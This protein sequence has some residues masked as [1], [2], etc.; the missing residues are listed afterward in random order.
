M[1]RYVYAFEWSHS[2][3]DGTWHRDSY[4]KDR[5]E[6]VEA[7]LAKFDKLRAEEIEKTGHSNYAKYHRIVRKL[8][9]DWEVVK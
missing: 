6:D 5:I 2:G 8:I 4:L 3:K 1:S 7:D 9:T